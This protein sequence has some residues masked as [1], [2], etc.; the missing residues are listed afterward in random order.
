MALESISKRTALQPPLTCPLL[1]GLRYHRDFVTEAEHD[2]LLVALDSRGQWKRMLARSLQNHG[3]L[4]HARGMIATPLPS[5]L[6]TVA[7][8]LVSTGVFTGDAPPNHVLVNRYEPGEGIEAHE[9]G[10]VF[11]PCAAIV[12]LQAPVV[13][14]FYRKRDSGGREREPIASIVLEPRS[15]LRIEGDAYQQHLHAIHAVHVDRT[16]NALLNGFQGGKQESPRRQR[17]S[18]T[19]RRSAKTLKF[20]L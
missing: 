11:M 10:P 9:D 1:Q 14:N 17:T 2:A 8:G 19:L 13:M 16:S 15:L 18:L 3:G 5:H 6:A 7:A 12:S 4:P 20:H